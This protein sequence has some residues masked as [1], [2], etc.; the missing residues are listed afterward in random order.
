MAGNL[1]LPKD[2]DESKQYAA[3]MVSHPGTSCKEQTSGIYA[4]RLAENGFAT[5]AFDASYQGESGGTPRWLDEAPS[6]VE[7]ISA[8]IDYV[9]T[10]PYVDSER[11]GAL[12]ICAGGGY[13]LNAALT[14][15]R[16]KVV[17]TVS[18]ADVGRVSRMMGAE[19]SI[20]QLEDFGKMRTAEMKRGEP[21]LIPNV[22]MPMDGV[23]DPD[24][25]EGLDYYFTERG[26]CDN[27]LKMRRPSLGTKTYA[28]DAIHLCEELLNQP[29]QVIV[30]ERKGMFGSNI[31]GYEVIERAASKDK[32][33]LE[34]KGASHFDLYDKEEYLAQ[35]VPCL[36]DFFGRTL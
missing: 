17:G 29:L 4:K 9:V 10:L 7:D 36:T 3:I 5:L 31:F 12:G 16:I 28:F 20:Q 13:T 18:A 24:L 22:A 35:T 14:E 33:I 25:V 8:A 30:G 32:S 19:A 26:Q 2:F 1:F 27:F 15:K 21:Q 23:T 34:V 6:R 11:V